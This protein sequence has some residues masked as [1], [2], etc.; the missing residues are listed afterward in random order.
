MFFIWNIYYICNSLIFAGS[1]AIYFSYRKYM[2]PATAAATSK[3][4]RKTTYA[5]S[6]KKMPAS[7]KPSTKSASKMKTPTKKRKK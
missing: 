6:A 4:A 2:T 1:F 5:N 3:K 7:K